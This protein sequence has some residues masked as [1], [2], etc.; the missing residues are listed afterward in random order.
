MLY[1]PHPRVFAPHS[2]EMVTKQAHKAECDIHNILGQYK[3]TGIINHT[4]PHQPKYQELPDNFDYQEALA[5]TAQADQAFATLP[6]SVRERY[7]HSPANFLAA[8]QTPSEEEFLRSVGVLKPLPDPTP[9]TP[10]S[11]QTG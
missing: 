11:T 9:S 8:L 7:Q 2:D 1:R 6:S 5:I 4:A 10:S 3:R